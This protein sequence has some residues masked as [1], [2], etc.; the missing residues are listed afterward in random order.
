MQIMV[1][2]FRTMPWHYNSGV[3]SL[4]KC[5]LELFKDDLSN[6][7]DEVL[8]ASSQTHKLKHEFVRVVQFCFKSPNKDILMFE[9]R[10]L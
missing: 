4:S 10:K 8:S 9:V 5:Y 1:Q 2:S 3:A 7:V 6:V